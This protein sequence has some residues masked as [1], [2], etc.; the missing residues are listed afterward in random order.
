MIS[1]VV[2]IYQ[3]RSEAIP[4]HVR[5]IEGVFEQLDSEQPATS[6]TRSFASTMGCPSF[7]SQPLTLPTG[8]TH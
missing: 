2:V 1:N 5:L 7:I 8:R 6:S 3:V 4:E